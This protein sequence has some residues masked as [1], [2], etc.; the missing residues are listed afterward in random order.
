M[1]GAGSHDDINTGFV[2]DGGPRSVVQVPM[3]YMQV[4]CLP[5][6]ITPVYTDH[7]TDE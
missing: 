6:R 5:D 7:D 2:T 3:F 1:T 4:A